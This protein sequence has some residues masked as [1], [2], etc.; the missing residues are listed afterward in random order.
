MVKLIRNVRDLLFKSRTA[1]NFDIFQSQIVGEF[2]G[3]SGDTRFALANGQ[4]WRQSSN[5]LA[6]HHAH[7]PRVFIYRSGQR[8]KM[9]VE[10]VDNTIY[11]ERIK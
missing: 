7:S 1:E 6:H 9:H 8:I 2:N 3:W 4:I 11:V 5:G 10:G